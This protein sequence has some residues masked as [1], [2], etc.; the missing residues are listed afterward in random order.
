MPLRHTLV[1]LIYKY[2]SVL[3]RWW[4]VPSKEGIHKSFPTSIHTPLLRT[5]L[6]NCIGN[7]TGIRIGI[8]RNKKWCN[9]ILIIIHLF[10]NN[11]I[12]ESWRQWNESI[13]NQT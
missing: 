11:T 6:V 9:V 12:M 13:L 5:R 8:T 4:F 2:G 1:K 10:G 7:Y 3:S